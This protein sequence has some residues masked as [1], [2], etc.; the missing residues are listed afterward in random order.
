MPPLHDECYS[1]LAVSSPELD[2]INAGHWDRLEG[3]LIVDAFEIPNRMGNNVCIFDI[4]GL[5]PIIFALDV[6]MTHYFPSFR[7]YTLR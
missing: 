7:K 1:A 6:S 2:S 5:Y 3:A 4:A